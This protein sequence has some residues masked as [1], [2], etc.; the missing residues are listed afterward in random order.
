MKTLR[1]AVRTSILVSF[2][3]FLALGSYFGREGT[4]LAQTNLLSNPGFE[5]GT[6]DWT[7]SPSTATTGADGTNPRSG[8]YAGYITKINGTTGT[9]DVYQDVSISEAGSGIYYTFKGYVLYPSSQSVNFNN[10]R[11]RIQWYNSS[12]SQI[13]GTVEGSD[14]PTSDTYQQL[15]II[16]EEALTGAV[17][18][19]VMLHLNLLQ[20][21]SDLTNLVLWDDMVFYRSGPNTV[22]LSAF[23]ASAVDGFRAAM[24]CPV[25]ALAA[26]AVLSLGRLLWARRRRLV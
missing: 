1:L 7:K 18:A 4:V 6:T 16:G 5:S 26:T 9:V 17:T 21:Q 22:T 25:A 24:V 2:V 10:V 23:A 19:R 11:L 20:G 12:G 3:T 8:S 13:G 14:A 15:S